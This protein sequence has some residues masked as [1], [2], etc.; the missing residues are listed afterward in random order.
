MTSSSAPSVRVF[1]VAQA[2]AMLP[3]VSA[4]V[5]DIVELSRDV[6]SRRERIVDLERRANYDNAPRV[7]AEELR[8]V[9][10][11][12]QSDS[13]RLQSYVEELRDLGVEPKSGP[14]GL[15]DFP[16]VIN[17]KSVYLCWKL[18]E[19]T[20][21]HWHDMDAG[22]AGRQPITTDCVVEN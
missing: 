8:L 1:T 18:G 20:V 19:P 5:A 9:K 11:E 3:L 15:V 17:G 16:A 14:E 22:F 21:S 2:N 7:Y 10:D 6:I 4:I 13:E 12:L